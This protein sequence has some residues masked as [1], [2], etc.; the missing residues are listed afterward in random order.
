MPNAATASLGLPINEPLYP[1]LED[2][3]VPIGQSS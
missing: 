2:L 1:I 3:V